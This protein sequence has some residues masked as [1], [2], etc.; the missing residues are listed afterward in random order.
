MENLQEKSTALEIIYLTDAVS[1]QK[2][3]QELL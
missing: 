2:I 3:K 1:W